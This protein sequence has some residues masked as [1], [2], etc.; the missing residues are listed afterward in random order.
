MFIKVMFIARLTSSWWC[1]T[2]C[3][4][5]VQTPCITV[6]RNVCSTLDSSIWVE[7]VCF[8]VHYTLCCV[9]TSKYTA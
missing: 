9:F 1:R 6:K 3:S 2:A 4:I 7:S 8:F 5:T